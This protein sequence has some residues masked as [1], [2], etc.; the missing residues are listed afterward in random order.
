MAAPSL[1][2]SSEGLR[3]MAKLKLLSLRLHWGEP[4]S[5]VKWSL[6]DRDVIYSPAPPVCEREVTVMTGLSIRFGPGFA[7]LGFQYIRDEYVP[8]SFEEEPTARE[9]QWT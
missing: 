9:E 5:K 4:A 8:V 3:E 6:A 7:F 1:P 2:A